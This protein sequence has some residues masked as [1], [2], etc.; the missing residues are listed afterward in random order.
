[1]ESR[2]IYDSSLEVLSP[3]RIKAE[4]YY[5]EKRRVFLLGYYRLILD[6]ICTILHYSYCNTKR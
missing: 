4:F 3:T 1:M 2:K 5:L 6:S